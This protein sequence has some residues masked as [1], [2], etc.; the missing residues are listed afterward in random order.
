VS[1]RLLAPVSLVALTSL[2]VAGAF[3]SPAAA[4]GP[5]QAFRAGAEA[6]VVDV[7]VEQRGRPVRGL[8]APDF[9]VL[10]NGVAQAIT[11]LS[12][13]RLPIDVTIAF[14]LSA[15]VTGYI[16]DQLRR[17]M[18]QL[19]SDLRPDDRLRVLTFNNHIRRIV[20][21]TDSAAVIDQAFQRLRPAGSSAILDTLAVALARPVS[22]DRRHLV[23]L[24]SDGHDTSSVNDT[25]TLL[26]AIRRTRPTVFAVLPSDLI[27]STGAGETATP[28]PFGMPGG[29][30]G[31]PTAHSVARQTYSVLAAESGGRAFTIGPDQNL[32]QTFSEALSQFRATYVL[33]FTPTGVASD[34]LHELTVR[35]KRDNVEV[36]ARRSYV[37]K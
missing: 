29:M 14:D 33:H 19:R 21:V 22:T 7:A 35:V 16:L 37:R 36:R 2:C 28:V 24:F 17:A 5:V 34:G 25:A 8:L 9:D 18:R 32:S 12:Y 6:V 31:P 1:A 27:R 26:E 11:D 10:D 20:D 23:V 15:S 4:Q 3:E 13:E 30:F